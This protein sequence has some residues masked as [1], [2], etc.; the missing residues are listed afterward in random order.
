MQDPVSYA[1]QLMWR[2]DTSSSQDHPEVNVHRLAKA[3]QRVITRHPALRTIFRPDKSDSDFFE[4]VLLKQIEPPVAVLPEPV[5]KDPQFHPIVT[6]HGQIPHHLTVYTTTSGQVMCRLDINH[7]IIDAMSV[8]FVERDLCRAYNGSPLSDHGD[9]YPKYLSLVQQQP[10]EPARA[11]WVSYL[12]GISPSDL[13]ASRT[14]TAVNDSS[15][16]LQ[17]L[18]IVLTH[19]GSDIECFSRWTD[20]TASNVLYFAWALTLSSFT[21][22]DEVC[23]GTLTSGRDWPIPHLGDAVGQFSNMSVCRVHLYPQTTL[24]QAAL[25]LQE[26][27]GHVLSHQT[28]PL[29][30]IARVAGV[31]IRE[32]ASTAVNVQYALP[33]DSS[34]DEESLLRLTPVN[35]QDPTL[36]G[37][38][39]FDYSYSSA[40]I[41]MA[42]IAR[43][44]FVCFDGTEWGAP[45]F[46]VLSSLAYLI[47]SCVTAGRIFRPGCF[48]Y[49][50]TPSC[51]AP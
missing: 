33:A 43:Y 5:D 20:W 21:G 39:T 49:P 3:W 29:A 22:T 38:P 47:S 35:G 11:Y 15:N 4:Q 46:H 30:Q 31:T 34:I 10:Q 26:H 18:D 41:G 44:H 25:C 32:L 8:A 2:V 16:S 48:D 24:D 9:T 37:V 42:M 28:F 6:R 36:V 27:Y 1:S 17:K 7:S 50:P 45:G 12:A 23:F 14:T 51:R 19:R 40:L 13:P